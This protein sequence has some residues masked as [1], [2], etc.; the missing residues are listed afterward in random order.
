MQCTDH[1][2]HATLALTLSHSSNMFTLILF[3]A[4][5]LT[6]YNPTVNVQRGL[7][8]ILHHAIEEHKAALA[9]QRH[10][11]TSFVL[12]AGLNRERERLVS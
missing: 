10:A 11:F 6:T 3:S 2:E 4:I 9:G 8:S 5:K 12:E 7:E 1:R